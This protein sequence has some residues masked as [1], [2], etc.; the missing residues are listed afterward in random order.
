MVGIGYAAKLKL[1]PATTA[2]STAAVA[3]TAGAVFEVVHFGGGW[4]SEWGPL[5][6]PLEAVAGRRYSRG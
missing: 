5:V 3:S 6:A 4:T 1:A 2:V